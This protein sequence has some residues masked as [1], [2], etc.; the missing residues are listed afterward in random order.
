MSELD[1]DI[2][3]LFQ[4]SYTYRFLI[5]MHGGTDATM[6]K[7][8]PK[9]PGAKLHFTAK[10]GFME[11]E[12]NDFFSRIG[13]DKNG[14]SYLIYPSYPDRTKLE[15]ESF[16]LK[17]GGVPFPDY[18]LWVETLDGI[19]PGIF[20]CR[21]N[22]DGK[23]SENC[24]PHIYFDAEITADSVIDNFQTWPCVDKVCPGLLKMFLNNSIVPASGQILTYEKS[25]YDLIEGVYS[26]VHDDPE[27]IKWRDDNNITSFE[28][29][30][31]N[32]QCRGTQKP[33][34]RESWLH[35]EPNTDAALPR[36]EFT[37]NGP[38]TITELFLDPLKDD[39]ENSWSA[40]G[41]L[42][43]NRPYLTLTV[44]EPENIT[45]SYEKKRE[46]AKQLREAAEQP[47]SAKKKKVNPVDELDLKALEAFA[48]S[49]GPYEGNGGT[50]KKK[51][52]TKK[53]K[54]SRK[55]RTS[56]AV[57]KTSAAVSKTSAAVSRTS[58][59]VSKTRRRHTNNK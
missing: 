9:M 53:T 30:I 50:R 40:L 43:R 13:V 48:N 47:R 25:L 33:Y 28:I 10:C 38:R 19:N 51:R 2:F 18:R 1:K 41:Y 54:R 55:S 14:I 5:S 58:A 7:T 4:T 6:F 29:E 34:H 37:Q 39:H 24:P 11:F 23:P 59:A 21:G 46:A 17:S 20:T 42:N 52:K 32:G 12:I 36:P 49:Y 57:S 26:Y 8:L 45:T 56:A 31:Y 22:L 27:Q 44:D 3:E 16:D 35:R 15:F